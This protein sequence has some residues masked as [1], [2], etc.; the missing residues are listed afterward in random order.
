MLLGGIVGQS[1]ERLARR[2]PRRMVTV[3]CRF[4]AQRGSEG[5]E[6]GGAVVNQ[7]IVSFSGRRERTSQAGS[8]FFR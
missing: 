6:V 5:S 1:P 8:F 4:A 7:Q 3:G 2:R